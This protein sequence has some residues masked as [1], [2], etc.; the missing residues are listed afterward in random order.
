LSALSQAVTSRLDAM[1]KHHVEVQAKVGAV[2]KRCAAVAAEGKAVLRACAQTIK[3]VK[4]L[5][6]VMEAV[7]EALVE[8]ER[9]LNQAR[10]VCR[11]P[12]IRLSF[13]PEKEEAK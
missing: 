10:R 9:W 12:P 13:P 2:E 8:A 6:G 7:A 3:D 5:D 4:E 11:L 1:E